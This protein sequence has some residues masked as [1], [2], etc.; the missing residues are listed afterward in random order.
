MIL[1]IDNAAAFARADL[2]PANLRVYRPSNGHCHAIWTLAKPVHR[3]TDARQGPI[4]LLSRIA[5]FYTAEACA[6]Q[7]Y[8]GVLAHNPDVQGVDRQPYETVRGV[9]RPYG[10]PELAEVIPFGWRAPKIKATGIG[11]NVDVHKAALKW[12]GQVR[13][14]AFDVLPTVMV[15]N[16]E[17]ADRLPLS[18]VRAIARSIEKYRARWAANGWHTPAWV[19]KQA[20]RGRRGGLKPSNGPIRKSA[21]PGVTNKAAKPWDDEG[22]SRAWWYEKRRRAGDWT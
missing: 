21:Q 16:A 8:A 19:R 7:G 14:S 3:Y 9:V 2:P 1:D 20:W 12:A 15:L 4:N 22:I 18:E 11:R 13:N 6:D 5:E 10:L 17:L